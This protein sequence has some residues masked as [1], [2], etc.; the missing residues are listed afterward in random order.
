MSAA[1]CTSRMCG[2]DPRRVDDG[3]G[4]VFRGGVQYWSENRFWVGGPKPKTA[5]YS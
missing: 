3:P 5:F 2:L 1:W 4:A